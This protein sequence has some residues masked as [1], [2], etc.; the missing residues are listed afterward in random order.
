VTNEEQACDLIHIS[1]S[2]A[3]LVPVFDA[4]AMFLDVNVAHLVLELSGHGIVDYHVV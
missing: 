4:V 1:N 2:F 3:D